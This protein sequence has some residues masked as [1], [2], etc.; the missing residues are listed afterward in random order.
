[1]KYLSTVDYVVIG[2]YFFILVTLGLI[3][4]RK[5][6]R[7]LED[8]FLGGRKM[9]WWALGIS[10]M[11]SHLDVAGT[12]LI[13][14][15]LFMLGP[16]GLFIEFRGGAVLILAVI[17]LWTGKWNRRSNCMTGAEW[18]EYR[19]G[20][21]AGGQ[22]ARII[23]A[24][25]VVL[26]AV[27]GLAYMTKGMGLFLSMFLPFPPV[28]CAAIMVG[29]ATLY[30]MVSGFYGVVYTD[31]FQSIIVLGAVLGISIMATTA[32]GG[33][34][35][36]VGTFAEQV[37]GTTNWE[38][39]APAT[40]VEM[41][42]GY[43][44]YN[45]L[46]LFAFVYLLKNVVQGAGMGQD[47]KYYGA[48]NER[49]CGT[50]TFIWTILITLRWPMMMGFAVLGLILVNRQFPD[51]S[52]L[53]DAEVEIKQYFVQQQHP[54]T[55]IDFAGLD[56]AGQ[57]IPPADWGDRLGA[58]INRPEDYTDAARAF[59]ERFGADWA[60]RIG[61]LEAQHQLISRIIP[62]AR[63]EDLL[64]R[65]NQDEHPELIDRLQDHLGPS[66]PMKLKLLSYQGT[67][68]PERV[69]PAVLLFEI[70]VGVRGL[71]LIALLAASMSTFDTGVNMSAAYFTRD[72]YQR[73]WRPR[74]PNRELMTVTYI[75]IAVVVGLGF[76]MGYSTTS[77]ND[78]WAWLTMAMWG[79]LLAP[80]ILKF[81]W[82]RFNAG[83]VIFGTIFGLTAAVAEH[84]FPQ[85]NTFM[86]QTF[87]P[88]WF[89]KEL[90]G[91]TYI[92]AIGSIGAILGTFFT[93]PNDPKVLTQFYEST[94]P[95]GFWGPMKRALP[96]DVRK[97]VS[98]EHFNDLVA[99]PFAL[100]WQISMFI[101][102][103]LAIIRN[104]D[105]FWPTLAV[106][107][108]GLGGLYVFWYRNLPATEDGV[109]DSLDKLR[110]AAA[111]K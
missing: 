17:M 85:I 36:D 81:Y 79:G 61:E 51:Q 41:P 38:S 39:A 42:K 21:G 68:N 11:A 57:V 89:P 29:V 74:A 70:P 59:E 43:E 77:I 13:V 30:T 63:W 2:V 107:L 88:D 110:A 87:F 20:K 56:L 94:R 19:F 64:A 58:I 32:V 5:A 1:M 98:R 4:S 69:L 16:R 97:Q 27:G 48:R 66:W 26:G 24:L 7:S 76:A 86:R 82:W 67:V 92:C 109:V 93:R 91:F 50:L 10:G 52:V 99:L 90:V 45:M 78:I 108:V 96:D 100:A 22:F 104:W 103:M 54:D 18:M 65:L 37:T 34:P 84:V 31:L 105:A 6:S 62:R 71:L 44:P 14:S 55:Q 12:M 111:R 60:A 3:L 75:Y 53:R 49:E 33:L 83:G 80:G 35:T 25:A 101:L 106:W 9:P 47:A 28:V 15:F 95:F 23:S 46:L 102:P 40:R 8:Y 73:Y 72:L